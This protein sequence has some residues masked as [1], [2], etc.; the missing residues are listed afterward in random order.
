MPEGLPYKRLSG[1]Y[2]FW[3]A[4]L[5]AFLP[6][7]GLYLQERGFSATQIGAVFGTLMGTKLIAPYVWGWIV[8]H[9]GARLTIVRLAA[10]LTLLIFCFIPQQAQFLG[11]IVLMTAYGFFWNATPPQIEALT[12]NHLGDKEAYYGRIRLWGSIGFITSVTS[13]GWLV[14]THGLGLLPYW[15]AAMLAGVVLISLLLNEKPRP[16]SQSDAEGLW[17]VLKR[18]EVLGLLLACCLMQLSHGPYYSFFSIYLEAHDYSRSQ[19]GLLWSLGVFAEIFV[20]LAMPLL[21]ARLGMRR[22][23]LMAIG[24]TV[25][26]W[27]LLSGFVDHPVVIICVQLMHLAS[28]GLYHAV[29]VNLVHRFFRGQLQGRGQALYSSMSF[30]LGGGIGA[31]LSGYVWDISSP[32]VIYFMAAV[33]ALLAWLIAWWTLHVAPERTELTTGR[34]DLV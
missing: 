32:T 11:M 25:I 2:F 9:F 4:T 6:Y 33:V 19:I 17:R 12:F 26:R 30:G 14:Q 16:E 15:I 18:P 3:F 7:W 10:A 34:T 22:L 21:A 31:L 24:I 13:L 23:F 28:F 29:A 8:D 5:G 20:F 27:A 1:F